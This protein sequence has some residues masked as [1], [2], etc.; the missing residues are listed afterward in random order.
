VECAQPSDF[1]RREMAFRSS[2]QR[3]IPIEKL[4][5]PTKT[6][7]AKNE[8]NMGFAAFTEGF[9]YQIY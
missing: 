6:S 5:D 2:P 1:E 3:W 7:N 4:E 9:A 8:A